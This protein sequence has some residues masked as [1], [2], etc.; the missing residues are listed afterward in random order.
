MMKT[1]VEGFQE[2]KKP[3]QEFQIKSRNSSWMVSLT[4][5]FLIMPSQLSNGKQN[6]QVL[7]RFDT[8]CSTILNPGYDYNTL[9]DKKKQFYMR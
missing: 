6:I 5:T 9:V 7:Q 3:I 1:F 4:N 8:R 2:P